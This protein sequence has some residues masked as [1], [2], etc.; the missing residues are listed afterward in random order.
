MFGLDAWCLVVFDGAS[1]AGCFGGVFYGF[2]VRF[3]IMWGW[4]NI[5]L[6]EFSGMWM[7]VVCLKCLD[8]TLWVSGL[9]Y[10]VAVI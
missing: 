7:G 8:S 1:V 6:F 10:A 4:Y 9:G 3:G 5:A 2:P